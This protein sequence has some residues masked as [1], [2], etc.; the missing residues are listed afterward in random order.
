MDIYKK[1]EYYRTHTQ[2]SSEAKGNE[3]LIPSSLRALKEHF[4]GEIIF[5]SAP[6]LKFSR[7]YAIQETTEFKFS[8]DFLS[9]NR[10]PGVYDL[11]QCLFFDLETTGL[12]GGAGTYAFLIGF[13]Y[14]KDGEIITD[15]YFLP[16]FGRE[17]HLFNALIDFFS[18]FDLLVSYNGKSYDLPLLKNRFLLNRLNP[19]LEE[20]P[21][22]DL[23]HVVRRIWGRS[24]RSCDLQTLERELDLAY[25]SNDIPGAYIPQAYFD[26]I[27][28]GTIHNIIRLVE[29]NYTD[30][31][32]LFEL[33]T[34]LKQINHDPSNFHLDPGA[35]YSL[36]KLSYEMFNESYLDQIHKQIDIKQHD[37]SESVRLWKSLLLKKRKA[38]RAAV[39]IWEGLISSHL[40]SMLALEELAK[41][42]EHISKDYTKALF[43]TDRA[44]RKIEL[45]TEI[46][47][48]EQS[49]GA[50]DGFRYRHKRLMQK[51]QL[52]Q[53]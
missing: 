48:L 27:N 31:T 37:L 21:H 18:G 41:Y 17:Y 40:Y 10:I 53:K 26:F 14:I 36:A 3:A 12:S 35:L 16:D 11:E 5:P 1:L 4:N 32:S 13:L 6:Y 39:E 19:K 45:M 2:K 42:Y 25:R 38:W 52:L 46:Y 51:S 20:M 15:Q 43:Y 22:L 23:L 47:E 29:H 44:I 33:V 8:V 50:I 34:I 30:L 9:R 7:R 28:T 24:L 49:D